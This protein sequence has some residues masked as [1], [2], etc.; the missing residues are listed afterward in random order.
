MI[1][2]VGIEGRV[3]KLMC[4]ANCRPPCLFSEVGSLSGGD[5]GGGVCVPIGGHHLLSDVVLNEAE[6]PADTSTQ[7]K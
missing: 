6:W 1:S 2:L 5:R 4:L 7:I 3:S